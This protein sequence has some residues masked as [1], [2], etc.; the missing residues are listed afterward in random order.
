MGRP[1]WNAPDECPVVW[2]GVKVNAEGGERVRI[3]PEMTTVLPELSSQNPNNPECT[4]GG[5]LC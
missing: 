2:S 5:A 4:R 1:A 3:E